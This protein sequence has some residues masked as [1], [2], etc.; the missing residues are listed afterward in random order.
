MPRSVL[1]LLNQMPHD[2]ASGAARNVRSQCEILASAGFRVRALATTA[3]EHGAGADPLEVLR[4]AGCE[5]E[6]RTLDAGVRVLEFAQRGIAYTLLDVGGSKPQAWEPKSG[7]VF[8]RILA[9]EVTAHPPDIVFGYGGQAGEV[10][11]RAFVRERGA[12]VVT[13]VLNLSYFHRPAFRD[14][15]AVVTASEFITDLYRERLGLVSTPLFSAFDLDDIVA[16]SRTPR[17][18]TYINPSLHKGVMFFARLADE[19][20]LERPE[21]PIMVI[22]SR[23]TAG[24]LVMAAMRGGF[25][26]RRHGNIMVSAGVSKPKHIYAATRVLVVPS[27]WEEPFGRVAAESLLNGIPPIVSDR[28]GLSEAAAGGGLVLA[29]PKALTTKTM[30]P[31]APEDVREWKEV[32]IR[33]MTDAAAYEEACARARAASAKWR[34][35]AMRERTLTFFSRVCRAPGR[36]P[37]PFVGPGGG[38][39]PLR[40]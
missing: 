20:C 29:L 39:A 34:P 5:P 38:Q 35:E 27:V 1:L 24:H 19:I 23:G 4:G 13:A 37:G 6:V 32:A 11:R 30:R 10:R 40:R 33:Q 25:D 28:G 21:I 2:P 3:T 26:L 17:Y 9:S 14:V 15:D 7:R 36:T 31:V 18:L 12:T 22:E 16:E 8:D